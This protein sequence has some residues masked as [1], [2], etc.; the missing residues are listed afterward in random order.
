MNA[1]W[2]PAYVAIGANLGNRL[3]TVH[4][5]FASLEGLP[6]SR[7][8]ARSRLYRSQ[9]LGPQDQ[10]EYINAAAGLLTQ[11][12]PVE[13]LNEL[14][15]L[16]RTL[17]REAPVIR[18][19]P[20]AIDFDLSV[21]G[22]QR[23]DTDALTVPHPGVPVRNFVLYPLLDIAPE[24]DVPGHGRIRELAARVSAEGLTAIASTT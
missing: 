4:R 13:L 23:V 17:G 22:S 21:F 14:K 20:R 12:S 3:A 11:L 6:R 19:G 15:A 24:L 8:I 1:L 18:W 16:E 2:V 7:L 9:P 10:P 5:A